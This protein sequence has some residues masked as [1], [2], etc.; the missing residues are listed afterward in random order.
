[1]GEGFDWPLTCAGSPSTDLGTARFRERLPL[2]IPALPSSSSSLSS[3]AGT[4]QDGF[5]IEA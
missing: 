4:V 2:I 1:M 5:N 3:F